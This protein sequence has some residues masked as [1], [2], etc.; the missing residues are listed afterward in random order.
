MQNIAAQMLDLRALKQT[1][2]AS[3]S[4]S[5]QK[6]TIAE[7]CADPFL[8]I[9]MSM[10]TQFQENADTPTQNITDAA[11][12]EAA[13]ISPQNLPLLL[14]LLN[15]QNLQTGQENSVL[16]NLQIGHESSVLQNLQ[17]LQTGQESSVL[18]NLNFSDSSIPL[19]LIAQLL[20]EQPSQINETVA[21]NPLLNQLINK[22]ATDGTN[23]LTGTSFEIPGLVFEKSAD[24]S[25]SDTLSTILSKNSFM[26]AVAI[27]KETLSKSEAGLKG[28]TNSNETALD[29][30]LLQSEAAQ[31]RT[32]APFELSFKT[33]PESSEPQ[34]IDQ[35]TTGIKQNVTL[36]KSEFTVKL[37]PESLGLI[38]VK[39][40]E[41]AGETVLS[42]TTASAQTAKLINSDLSSLREAIA[43]MNVQ[44]NEA[45]IQTDASSQ[46][47]MQQYNMAG[48]QFEGQQFAGQQNSSGF[49]SMPSGST[50]DV[51]M[52]DVF[53]EVAATSAQITSS[54][55]LDTY[56]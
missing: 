15:S 1:N 41:K 52:P 6:D 50:D 11:R 5:K 43:P 56:I 55:L 3:G 27:V 40:V 48:Q 10:L 46:S 19:D 45:V 7:E 28:T 22:S 24:A 42:I 2:S 29:V 31:N 38:T 34:L 12:G 35:L 9:I 4:S 16:Q 8:Q 47:D 13:L 14:S 51:Y 21:E 39:L 33:T 53:D 36:G 18:Q 25:D 44:V 17:S 20:S 49:S 23:K 54:D 37:K 30:D 32:A 26:E